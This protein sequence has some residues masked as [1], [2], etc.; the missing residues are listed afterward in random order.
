MELS[1]VWKWH[2]GFYIGKPHDLSL[3]CFLLS[4]CVTKL[5]CYWNENLSDG[6]HVS[7][8]ISMKANACQH[9]DFNLFSIKANIACL[10][11]VSSRKEHK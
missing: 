5:C 1:A 10:L 7:T 6:I 4:F 8:N 11:V 2:G 3:F 9:P